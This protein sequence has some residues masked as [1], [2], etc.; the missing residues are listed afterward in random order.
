MN[1]KPLVMKQQVV[2]DIGY[3]VIIG[4]GVLRACRGVIDP[5]TETLTYSPAWMSHACPALRCSVPLNMSLL[6]KRNE[7]DSDSEISVATVNLTVLK[8]AASHEEATLT[9]MLVRQPR[10]L[11]MSSPLTPPKVS[12]AKHQG[13]GK[14]NQFK[15]L[16]SPK[17]SVRDTSEVKLN[18]H[19][20]AAMAGVPTVTSA[21]TTVAP[22]FPQRPQ[23]LDK[24]EQDEWALK[25]AA[26]NRLHAQAVQE[27]R[28]QNQGSQQ[29]ASESLMKPHVIGFLAQDL[30]K[31]NFVTESYELDC[32]K[33][34]Q[35]THE[36]DDRIVAKVLAK[37]RPLIEALLTPAVPADRTQAAATPDP[38]YAQT[39][40]AQP[41]AV[42]TSPSG[43]PLRR[44]PRG[45]GESPAPQ[46]SR[47]VEAAEPTMASP[48]PATIRRVGAVRRATYPRNS[49]FNSRVHGWPSLRQSSEVAKLPKRAQ[50]SAAQAAAAKALTALTLVG[51]T[52]TASAQPTSEA[53]AFIHQTYGQDLAAVALALGAVTAI[54]VSFSIAAWFSKN[55]AQSMCC[56][57]MYAVVTAFTCACHFFTQSSTATAWAQ[58]RQS[59]SA[60]HATLTLIPVIPLGAWLWNHLANR[61]FLIVWRE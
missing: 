50:P 57:I 44:S 38:T 35:H 18:T 45:V 6:K 1:V 30:L 55:K 17:T 13:K 9:S 29:A 46:A 10:Y 21:P 19:V 52:G 51:M 2:D 4:Q 42:P 53:A 12:A 20:Q 61:H 11:S 43:Q 3:E 39:A 60:L 56:K 58:V 8:T 14:R 24:D 36:R 40:A 59:P 5:L 28:L 49:W 26:R 31:L 47:S 16:T 37:L 23:P 34:L 32:S 15:P 22:G 54:Y 25:R 27:L 48:P 7:D 33:T 41:T